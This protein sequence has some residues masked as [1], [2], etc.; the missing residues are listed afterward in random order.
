MGLP[1]RRKSIPPPRLLWRGMTT[2]SKWDITDPTIASG[3]YPSCCNTMMRMTQAVVFRQRI[4][5]RPPHLQKHHLPTMRM[6]MRKHP[7]R[8]TLKSE[9]RY[10]SKD[11]SWTFIASNGVRSW[12][13]HGFAPYRPKDPRNTRYIVSSMLHR[14]SIDPSKSSCLLPVART[15]FRTIKKICPGLASRSGHATN[16]YCP[17]TVRGRP[18]VHYVRRNARTGSRVSHYHY[19]GHGSGCGQC[20]PSATRVGHRSG[21][22]HYH[23]DAPRQCPTGSV[24]GRT[25]TRRKR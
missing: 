2:R 20:R 9:S 25:R 13:I 24:P 16:R 6:P 18:R 12:T 1:L 10:A 8:C 19:R 7:P 11:T 22:Q 3:T 23:F 5:P 14:A 4:P 15:A 17:G 21:Q